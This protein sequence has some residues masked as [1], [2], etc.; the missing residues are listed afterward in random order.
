MPAYTKTQQ[1]GWDKKAKKPKRVNHN[2]GSKTAKQRG[3]VSD[4]AYAEAWERSGA[5][6][7]MCGRNSFEAWTL[8]AAHAARRWT[9]GQEGVTAQD[10]V[11]LCGPSTDSHT[12]HHIADYTSAGR[13]W[14]AEY[15]QKL[16][17]AE[18]LAHQNT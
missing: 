3:A 1:L 5:R 12:C 7:E 10:I 11:I 16:R 14:L 18:R 13:E 2:R 9:Y 4:E 17:E 6:C 8:E 15:S